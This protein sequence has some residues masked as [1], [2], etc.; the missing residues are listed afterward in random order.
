[1]IRLSMSTLGYLQTAFNCP[2]LETAI[3]RNLLEVFIENVLDE[4]EDPNVAP[5]TYTADRE[6]IV[7][8]MLTQ[9]FSKPKNNDHEQ[10]GA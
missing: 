2:D 7:A 10:D 8:I 6:L 4:Q 3:R 5:G 1:M 9:K